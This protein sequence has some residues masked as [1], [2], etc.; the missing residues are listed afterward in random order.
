MTLVLCQSHLTRHDLAQTNAAV[1][2]LTRRGH[3]AV[4]DVGTPEE[5]IAFQQ[6]QRDK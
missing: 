6:T 3:S 5:R 2:A 4:A 1:E